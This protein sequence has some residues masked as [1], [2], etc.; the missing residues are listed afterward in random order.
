MEEILT[1]GFLAS[2]ADTLRFM[3]ALNVARDEID[4]MI[5]GVRIAIQAV[6]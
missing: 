6:R 1:P 5:E 3:P 2:V 4:R